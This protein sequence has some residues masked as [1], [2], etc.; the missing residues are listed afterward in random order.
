[1][2]DRA[3]SP[4]AASGV[5]T[6]VF[7]G[8]PPNPTD[9]AITEA[10]NQAKSFG[11]QAIIGIGGGS[12]MDA[13]KG[14]AVM[15]TNTGELRSFF[16]ALDPWP[17]APLPVI[18]VPTNAGTGSE[19][20]AVGLVS[21]HEDKKKMAIRGSSLVSTV[22]VC[23]PELTVGLPPHLTAATG[24]DAL[25]HAL[26]AYVCKRMPS[27]FADVLAERSIALV[28]QNL[29]RACV[30][31]TDLEARSN[32]MLAS[33]MGLMAAA[34]SGGLG[35]VHA[36]AHAQGGY[37]DTPHNLAIAACL[38]LG[39]AYNAP[40]VEAKYANVTGL[41]GVDTTE[42]TNAAAA[43]MAAGVVKQLIVDVG[44]DTS[45]VENKGNAADIDS[46]VELSMADGSTP[47]NPRPLNASAF[48]TLYKQLFQIRK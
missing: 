25:S 26:E 40:S 27:P 10:G 36:M 28:A 18:A 46:L 20:S 5:E 2:L 17:N 42:L 9:A 16:G 7:D 12:P 24:I 38:P 6:A 31:G 34:N 19:V 39:L 15:A 4:L 21:F 23:D 45:V 43:E 14:V 32:M 22:A 13:A 44:I 41:M 48:E 8:V 47:A 11:A 3:L 33:T 30:D 35:V 1:M 37:F 29:K